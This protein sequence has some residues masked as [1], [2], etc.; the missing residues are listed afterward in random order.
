MSAHGHSSRYP[1]AASYRAPSGAPAALRA[2]AA[3]VLGLVLLWVVAELVPAAHLRDAI[4][5]RHFTLLGSPNVNAIAGPLLDLLDPLP[6]ALIGSTLV[7]AGIMR[8][9]RREALAAAAI[10]VLAPLSAEVLK[11][12]LAHSHARAGTV[13][14][15][16][17]SWPSGHSAAA[18]ALAVSATI[19]APRRARA[20]VAILG[21]GFALAVGCA[22]LI[23]AWHMPSDVLGGYLI[24]ALWG[25]LALAA[26]RAGE[27]RWPA[28]A[29]LVPE[30]CAPGSHS[31]SA[32]SPVSTLAA[33]LRMKSRSDSRL[34]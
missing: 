8:G 29:Q 24:A 27:R 33:L 12:L 18:L 20:L 11:P 21:G 6:L 31:G 26:L 9:R 10:I 1:P 2:A 22:L 4:L 17:A 15:A 19:L 14:I 30:S 5:L 23:Q 34:R 28:A 32:P 13:H 16:A 7:L 3:C 25:A